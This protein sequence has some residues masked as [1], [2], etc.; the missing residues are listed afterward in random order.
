[1]AGV[2][3]LTAELGRAIVGLGRHHG[4]TTLLPI[5]AGVDS[6]WL[7]SAAAGDAADVELFTFVPSGEAAPIDAVIGAEVAARLGLPHRCLELPA[8]VDPALVE[9]V[10]SVR[11]RWRDLPKMA[12]LQ[13]LADQPS[14]A[15]ILNGNGGE[16]IR[17][18]YYG[19][20]PVVGGRAA[21]RA[22]CLGP[23][24]DRFDGDGF[25]RWYAS[26]ERRQQGRAAHELFYW[27][28][29]MAHWGS[30]F[31]AEK[32][33]VADE[34]SPYCSRRL[35]RAGPAVVGIGRQPDPERALAA[36][37]V[38]GGLGFNPHAPVGALRRY[39]V[40]RAGV[41]LAR[42]LVGRRRRRPLPGGL[43]APEPAAAGQSEVD[44][45]PAAQR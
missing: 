3:E 21:V 5:T 29:R 33:L 42:D 30:D 37:P 22:L 43:S 27:E 18:G 39:A 15:M 24:P 11:G 16:I 31:Y 2:E 26:L 36:D 4:R 10:R 8:T 34:L 44:A 38:F 32:Q 1:P 12:E 19:L 41:G 7:A 28:Q 6:R 20:G 14:R 9:Q 40:V 45:T 35:L 25:D 13:Y 23:N 17:G